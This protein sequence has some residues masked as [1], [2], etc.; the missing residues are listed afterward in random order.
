LKIDAKWFLIKVISKTN[1]EK[2]MTTDQTAANK[3]T[4]TSPAP[5]GKTGMVC[6]AFFGVILPA[7]TLILELL[8]RMCA[9]ALFDPVPTV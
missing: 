5:L 4:A 7:V 3:S 9:G 2:I 8:T 1:R 6:L